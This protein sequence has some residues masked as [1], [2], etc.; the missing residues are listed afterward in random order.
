MLAYA[1]RI[2]N[3]KDLK[4]RPG[5]VPGWWL[6][7]AGIAPGQLLV[8]QR[9]CRPQLGLCECA[10]ALLALVRAKHVMSLPVCDSATRRCIRRQI[11][12]SFI[13]CWTA[14]SNIARI[15]YSVDRFVGKS[16]E[17]TLK[18]HRFAQ[19]AVVAWCA[20]PCQPSLLGKEAIAGDPSALG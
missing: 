3:L 10:E 16:R 14:K 20:G 11:D 8:C 9:L 17:S 6:N 7:R 13:I 2:H 15:P 18:M 1:G 5:C 4:V 19:W 12:A